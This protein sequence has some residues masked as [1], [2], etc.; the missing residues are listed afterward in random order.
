MREE[1]T[2]VEG[3]KTYKTDTFKDLYYFY[4]IRY[5]E[6]YR[7]WIRSIHNK[8]VLEK[9]SIVISCLTVLWI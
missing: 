1:K 7:K 8:P 9:Y 5:Y 6:I 2:I 4:N 3:I